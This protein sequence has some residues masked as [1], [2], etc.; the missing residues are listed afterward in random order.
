N[1]QPPSEQQTLRSFAAARH[2]AKILEM[3][4][5]IKTNEA[6]MGTSELVAKTEFQGMI[7]QFAAQRRFE[8]VLLACRFYRN[9]FRDASGKIVLEDGSAAQKAMVNALGNSPT[10]NALDAFAS[11]AIRDVDE[12]ISSFYNLLDRGDLASAS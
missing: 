11:E 7:L 2:M 8:H 5:K 12:G 6:L 9:L 4:A 10:I 3:E 1:A